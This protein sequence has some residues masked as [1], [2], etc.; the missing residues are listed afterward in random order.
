[1]GQERAGADLDLVWGQRVSC[2]RRQQTQFCGGHPYWG[3][4]GFP[5]SDSIGLAEAVTIRRQ[6]ESIRS[7][8]PVTLE[9]CTVEGNSTVTYTCL[10]HLYFRCPIAPHMWFGVEI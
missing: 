3:W 5:S 1:M 6:W 2:V 9:H 8:V 10:P 7:F 4:A